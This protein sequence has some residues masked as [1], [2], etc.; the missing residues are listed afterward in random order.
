[1]DENLKELL[2]ERLKGELPGIFAHKKLAPS[3]RPTELPGLEVIEKAKKAATLLLLYFKNK[4]AYFVLIQRVSYKGVHS[5]Q[6]AFPGGKQ[7]ATDADFEET[8][9]RETE[10][11]I[12][13]LQKDV[14]IIGKLSNIYIPPSNFYVYPYIGFY[15]GKDINFS[16]Q[17]TEVAKVIEVPLK[18]L[19]KE[20]VIQN[21]DVTVKNDSK[22]TV[23]AFVLPQCT[24]WGATAIILSEFCEILI[25]NG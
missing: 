21:I 20:N 15:K 3:Y 1:M 2:K 13:V 19:L 17:L 23:P 8:A 10:E 14:E 22:M 24:I 25:K 18:E 9:L 4:E 6:I 11:E 16:P 12:G 7:E 5:G